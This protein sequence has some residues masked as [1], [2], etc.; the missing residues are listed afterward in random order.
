MTEALNSC[1]DV[2]K[3]IYPEK[4]NAKALVV[5]RLANLQRHT[6]SN[7]Y[8]LFSKG[9]TR[10]QSII[11]RVENS[12]TTGMPARSCHA[13]ESTLIKRTANAH[14]KFSLP[15]FEHL[16]AKLTH[17]LHGVAKDQQAI[18]RHSGVIRV[19]TVKV[20]THDARPLG[21]IQRKTVTVCRGQLCNCSL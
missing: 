6:G 4:P 21:K 8:A 7:L 13:F 15:G 3:L 5:G 2:L 12:N 20:G 14:A 18:R 9:L 19:L 11:I 10:V 16:E 17:L 1:V